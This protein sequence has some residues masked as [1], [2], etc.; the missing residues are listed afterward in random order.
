[1]NTNK[2]LLDSIEDK[3]LDLEFKQLKKQLG[4]ERVLITAKPRASSSTS[5][6][7]RISK[8]R[9]GTNRYEV[10][11]ADGSWRTL[12]RDRSTWPSWFRESEERYE[13]FNKS[14][15]HGGRLTAALVVR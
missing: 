6:Q 3:I 5:H 2:Q 1:M 13:E 8:Q 10:R 9:D 7:A 11:S 4:C 12:S 14:R 15:T